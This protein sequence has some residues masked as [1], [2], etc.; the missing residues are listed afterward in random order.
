VVKPVDGTS[1]KE[2]ASAIEMQLGNIKALTSEERN[3]MVEPVL[4]D[5]DLWSLGIRSVLFFLS[6][7]LV[8]VVAMMS[9][10]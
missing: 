9:V 6:M 3:R 5:L 10:S 7:I 1:Q 4:R 8:A 2:L